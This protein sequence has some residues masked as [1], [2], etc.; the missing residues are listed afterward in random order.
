[1]APTKNRKRCQRLGPRCSAADA[2][3]ISDPAA[4]V[5]AYAQALVDAGG[6]FQKCRLLALT[7]ISGAWQAQTDQGLVS[8][9]HVVLALGPWSEVVLRPLGLRLPLIHERGQH[10]HL[11]YGL[12]HRLSRPINDTAAAYV[13]SPMADAYRLTTGVELNQHAAPVSTAAQ[14]QLAQAVLAAREAVDLGQPMPT[15]PWLGSRP[16]LP[17][18]LPR[19]DCPEAGVMRINGLYRHG[20]LI[21]PA[22]VDAALAWLLKGERDLAQQW[23]LCT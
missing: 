3:A 17:D 10:Q 5:R 1:M 14:A 9:Q 8:A 4:L 15:P 16:T 12:G 6:L 20:Y 7:P 22:V 13:L 19:I 2:S 23:Q 11:A 18:N 21:A